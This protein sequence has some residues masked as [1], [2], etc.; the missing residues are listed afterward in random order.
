MPVVIRTCDAGLSAINDNWRKGA[1]ALGMSRRSASWHSL[2]PA[3]IRP[4][5]P[6]R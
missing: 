4:P 5:M 3:A 2:L 1:L 6:R